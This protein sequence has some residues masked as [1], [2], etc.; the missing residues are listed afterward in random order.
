MK[1]LIILL[2]VMLMAFNAI[3]QNKIEVKILEKDM[4]QGTQTAFTMLIPESKAQDIENMWRKYVNNRPA[5]ER[6]KN[7]TTGVGNIFKPKEKKA[8]RD[9]LKMNKTGDEMHVRSIELDKISS[10]PVDIYA[11]ITQLPQGSQLSAFFQYTDSVFI[12]PSNTDEG[13][14]DLIADFVDEFGVEAY[15]NVV[16]ENIK[17]ANRDLSKEEVVLKGLHTSIL[18]S[19]KSII[20]DQTLIQEYNSKISELRSDSASIIEP[21]ALKKKEFSEMHEDSLDYKET[22]AELKSLEK[23]KARI[24]K[25]ISTL[26]GKVKSKELEIGSAKKQMAE[27]KLGIKNQ[28]TV[29]QEKQQIAEQLIKEKEE[30]Q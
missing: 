24:P 9:R 23:E 12:D 8:S 14:L 28:E 10:Y 20:R 2:V 26:K 25:E 30:I 27:N 19:E 3:S 29:I 15:R 11:I 22:K 16:D 1:L 7:L 6:F 18:R 13:K 5:N 4:S 21:I 17:L